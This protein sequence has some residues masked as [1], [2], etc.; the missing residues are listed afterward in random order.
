MRYFILTIIAFLILTPFGSKAQQVEVDFCTGLL[1]VVKCASMDKDDFFYQIPDTPAK[2]GAVRIKPIIKDVM[3]GSIEKVNYKIQV[4]LA[5][6]M[7]KENETDFKAR[8]KDYKNKVANCLDGW[9]RTE[10]PNGN[11]NIQFADILYTNTEDET[12]V[13]LTVEFLNDQYT[14]S[15]KVF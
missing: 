13:R 9:E 4:S 2:V 6:Y 11:K 1:N 8:L 5:L 10:V 14:V 15:V 12:T 7:G 3:T